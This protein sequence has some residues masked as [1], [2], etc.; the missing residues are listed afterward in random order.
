MKNM[1]K[2]MKKAH[3][4]VKEIVAKFGDV[5]YAAQLGLCISY[6]LDGG[7]KKNGNSRIT[8]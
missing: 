6:L 5:D 4:M 8:R 3:K 7:N 2:V 1:S